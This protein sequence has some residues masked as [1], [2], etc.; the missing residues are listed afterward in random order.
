MA[1]RI[2]TRKDLPAKVNVKESEPV[3]RLDTP[4]TLS[5][6]HRHDGNDFCLHFCNQAEV[7]QIVD[8]FWKLTT[9]SWRQVLQQGGGNK[10]GL[11]CTLYEDE[12]LRKVTRPAWLSD[13][14][15]IAAGRASRKIRIFGAY[16]DHVFYVIWFDRN[17]EIVPV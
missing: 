2:K 6:Q 10:T 7:K 8:A 5:F 15:K 11:A 4:V 16:V 14:V 13:D 12:A 3:S 1:K 17:H 9:L